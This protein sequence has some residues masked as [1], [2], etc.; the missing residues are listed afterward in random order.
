MIAEELPAMPFDRPGVV[1][2][3]PMYRVLQA[4]GPP[5]RVRTPTGDL[6]WLVTGY[7]QVRRLAADGRLGRSHPDPEHAPRFSCSAFGGAMGAYET[8][9]DDHERLR[10]LLMRSF[11]VKRMNALRPRCQEIVDDMCTR[12]AD[13]GPPADLRQAL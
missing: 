7:E 13:A 5:V 3:A 12:M 1:D 6:A 10:R 11:M 9:K 2:I 8:E 4:K